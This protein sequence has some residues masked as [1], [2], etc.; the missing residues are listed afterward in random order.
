[1]PRLQPK[2]YHPPAGAEVLQGVDA[3]DLL[4]GEDVGLELA[5]GHTSERLLIDRELVEA[6]LVDLPAA[7]VGL[8][9]L[10]ALAKFPTGEEV[11]DVEGG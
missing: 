8:G 2:R 9:G 1:M 6:R 4:E 7:L 10:D 3:L 5:D 11:L